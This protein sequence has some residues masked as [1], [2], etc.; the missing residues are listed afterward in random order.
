LKEYTITIGEQSAALG[1]AEELVV[2]L[3]V[4]QG[5]HDREVLYTGVSVS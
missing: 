2:A 5:H 3:D 4:L 1:T